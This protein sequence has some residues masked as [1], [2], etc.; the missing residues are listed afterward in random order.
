MFTPPTVRIASLGFLSNRFRGYP[1]N[2]KDVLRAFSGI[3]RD[4]YAPQPDRGWPRVFFF[5]FSTVIRRVFFLIIFCFFR[6]APRYYY[7]VPGGGDETPRFKPYNRHAALYYI[8]T[9]IIRTVCTTTTTPPPAHF[10]YCIGEKK[11]IFKKIG[12]NCS[13]RR[14]ARALLFAAFPYSVHRAPH[15]RGTKIFFLSLPLYT[16]V[17][18]RHCVGCP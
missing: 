7:E 15:V 1:P 16:R 6:H 12:Q 14:C 18:V 2:R 17:R 8:I 9:I 13:R 11:K 10:T 3:S 5:F 4:T